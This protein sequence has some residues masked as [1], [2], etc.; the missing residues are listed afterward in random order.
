MNVLFVGNDASR[1]GAP[2]G[3]LHLL[4]W[5]RAHTD[6]QCTLLLRRSG[7]PLQ[8]SYQAL[9]PVLGYDT[10]HSD[11]GLIRRAARRL[12]MRALAGRSCLSPA[13]QHY[14][15]ARID[16]IYANTIVTGGLVADLAMLG[17][18]VLCHVH[19]LQS[20]IDAYGPRNMAHLR[21]HSTAF[22]ADS[23]ATRRNLLRN[24][25]AHPAPVEVVYECVA[26]ADLPPPADPIAGRRALGISPDAFVVGGCGYRY[27][28]KG[29]DLFV[30]MA[31][32]MRDRAP[33]LDSHFIWVG[34]AV[35]DEDARL[36]NRDIEA[37][38]LGNRVH[39]VPHVENPFSYYPL[40]D[41]L[42]MTSREEPFGMV[43]LEAAC[44]ERP[45]ICFRDTG[46]PEE[47][48]GTDCGVT[49]PHLD[50]DAMAAA[51]VD[52]AR[53]PARRAAL[54]RN[55]REKALQH[56][57]VGVVAPLLAACMRRVARASITGLV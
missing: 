27:H 1:T 46:G 47:F 50:V 42:A 39:V 43:M 9:C 7:G 18:P 31:R 57:E 24:L 36:L 21:R 2:I 52:L 4:R 29:K 44:Y 41:V 54:G 14:Q 38:G 37:A 35:D 11:H 17:A 10:L 49:V 33:D 19:E 22:V 16:L 55:A 28:R 12:G 56:H 26:A 45:T 51:A 40:F 15:D 34:G 25:G 48:V 3:L 32:A 13:E 53:A 6:V 30:R 20:V 8:S 5:L 23:E